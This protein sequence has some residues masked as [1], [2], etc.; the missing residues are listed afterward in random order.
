MLDAAGA[1]PVLHRW[2]VE[3]VHDPPSEPRRD[4]GYDVGHM[5]QRSWT[6]HFL[7]RRGVP[8]AREALDVLFRR[9][10]ESFE[11]DTLGAGPIIELDG[12]A[13][14][15][16]VCSLLGDRAHQRGQS[17]VEDFVLG[18]FDEDL[19]HTAALKV[20]EHHRVADPGVDHFL[21]LME[22]TRA[23]M[24]SA[25]TESPRWSSPLSGDEETRLLAMHADRL[26]AGD[27]IGWVRHATKPSD[28]RGDGG[29][30]LIRWG[31]RATEPD[32]LR[33]LD[34]LDRTT[35][36]IELQRLLRVFYRTAP[37]RLTDRLFAL[38]D[39]PDNAVRKRAFRALSHVAD[40]RVRA[41]ALA[42]LTPGAMLCSSLQLFERN[43]APGDQLRVEAALFL[44]ESEEDVHWLYFDVAD[45]CRRI[46]DPDW[47]PLMLAVY[48]HSPCGLCRE[49]VVK[50]MSELGI[51]PTWVAEECRFDAQD[52]IR[53]LFDGPALDG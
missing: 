47:L 12:A 41:L 8:G 6:L 27:V 25:P 4:G 45:L 32:L 28:D 39:H 30:W 22:A 42:S 3:H 13:G 1:E 40:S 23:R 19:E 24:A 51:T 36:P 26:S 18:W 44:P 17:E 15:V 20:L 34:E 50:T 38:A 14:L 46:R 31:F 9:C 2:F 49:R 33:I 37:P 48:E 35:C 53:E 10:L 29:A 5:H 16:R 21:T 52:D 11:N 7:A 43:H